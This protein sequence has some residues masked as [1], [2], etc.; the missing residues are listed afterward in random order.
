MLELDDFL[1]ASID[2]FAGQVSAIMGEDIE[3]GLVRFN[4]HGSNV[5]FTGTTQLVLYTLAPRSI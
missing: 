1:P 4:T 3:G 5:G 2:V